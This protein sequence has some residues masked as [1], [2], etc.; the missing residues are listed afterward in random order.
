MTISHMC[1]TPV[2]GGVAGDARDAADTPPEVL[3][4]TM[5]RWPP[6]PD[7]DAPQ[8]EGWSHAAPA[9]HIASR[10]LREPRK[11]GRQG[12]RALPEYTHSRR[13]SPL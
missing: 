1:G 13:L 11:A 9:P 8:H 3:G 6:C 4:L 12:G 10:W 2:V 7:H 5:G